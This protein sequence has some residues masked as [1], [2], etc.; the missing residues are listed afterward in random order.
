MA[1]QLDSTV[2]LLVRLTVAGRTKIMNHMLWT[3]A[4]HERKHADAIIEDR[5]LYHDISWQ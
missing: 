3:T 5:M 4:W 1:V 2:S